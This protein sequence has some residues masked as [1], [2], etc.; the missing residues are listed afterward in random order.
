MTK[1]PLTNL[2]V[3]ASIVGS[4][5]KFAR[6]PKKHVTPVEVWLGNLQELEEPLEQIAVKHPLL[7]TDEAKDFSNIEIIKRQRMR[8]TARMALRFL[9]SRYF[10]PSIAQQKFEF[11]PHGRPSISALQG[12]FNLAH[13]GSYALVALG[14]ISPL[15]VDLETARDVRITAARRTALIAAAEEISQGIPLPEFENARSL[16][17]WTRLEA[18]AKAEGHGIGRILARYGVWGTKRSEDEIATDKN[19]SL[20]V[21]DLLVG[22]DNLHAA[23]CLPSGVGTPQVSNLPTNANELLDVLRSGVKDFSQ[24]GVDLERLPRQ[25]V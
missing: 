12:D 2:P 6:F 7:S 17:A 8:R 25:K 14:T 22:S 15:G 16:Q 23:V 3:C 1:V 9:L 4:L 24:S 21:Q 18:L 13:A 5:D 10:G 20:T 11:G 19:T